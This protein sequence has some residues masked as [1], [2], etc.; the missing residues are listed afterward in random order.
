MKNGA[1]IDLFIEIVPNGLSA[2]ACD[3]AGCSGSDGLPL[4]VA[5]EI[6]SKYREGVKSVHLCGLEPTA[7]GRL[8]EL[9]SVLDMHAVPYSVQSSGNWP[10]PL[11][12]IGAVSR[13]PAFMGFSF[14]L[15]I[16]GQRFRG[17]ADGSG[18]PSPLWKAVGAVSERGIPFQVITEIREQ[19][20][21]R[22]RELISLSLGSGAFRHLF[23]RYAGPLRDG[24][25]INRRD[26][27][28]VLAYIGSVAEAGLPVFLQSCFPRC[29]STLSRGCR[30]GEDFLFITACGEV[31]PC[32]F[33]GYQ[34]GSLLSTGLGDIL[35]GDRAHDWK[36]IGSS[37]CGRCGM[38]GICMGGCRVFQHD[39]AMSCD[40]LMCSDPFQ[41]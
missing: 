25:S 22:M 34:Y 9:I 19:N 35:S 29:F 4:S 13:S 31:K 18:S 2:G 32:R 15:D 28:K 14:H 10:E 1:G 39:Y 17:G 21:K 16:P 24:L 33:T 7:Y 27:G 3:D 30:A 23:S 12:L 38:K 11:R 41:L 8:F 20:R 6:L 36:A 5:T 37:A 40:P 26:L